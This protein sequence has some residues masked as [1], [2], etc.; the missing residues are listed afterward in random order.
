MVQMSSYSMTLQEVLATLL[1]FDDFD[2]SKLTTKSF[3]E[4]GR[5]RLF[6]FDYPIFDP[7]YKAVLETNFIRNFYM[8]EIGFESHERF[9]FELESWLLINMRYFNKLFESELMEFDPLVNSKMD[10][11]ST[12]K[13]DTDGTVDSTTNGD[14][15][16]SQNSDGFNRFLES[17]TPDNR[18]AITTEDGKGI[19]Q[20]ASK[21]NEGTTKNNMSGADSTNVVGNTLTDITETETY[22]QSRTGKTGSVTYSKMLLEYRNTLIRV[23]LKMFEEMQ[24]LFMLVY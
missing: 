3:I 21:I 11:S 17:D 12:R 20:Y 22:V 16:T 6:N 10:T 24:K 5:K 4:E 13:K 9:Q 23:E 1:A 7:T 2:A 8:R 18:L 14:T 19:I 15:T